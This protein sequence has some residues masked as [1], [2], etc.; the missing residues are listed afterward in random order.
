MENCVCYGKLPHRK[1]IDFQI[2]ENVKKKKRKP[3]ISH[4]IKR[5]YT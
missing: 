2:D 4:Q 3:T 5:K 1:E